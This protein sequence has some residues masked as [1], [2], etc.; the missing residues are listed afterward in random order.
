LFRV[1]FYRL[2][3]CALEARNNLQNRAKESSVENHAVSG[4]GALAG[5]DIA[6]DGWRVRVAKGIP[7]GASYSLLCVET[8]FSW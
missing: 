5:V 2:S 7:A 1:R 6:R 3:Y 4:R 8:A